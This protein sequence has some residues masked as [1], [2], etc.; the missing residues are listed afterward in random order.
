MVCSQGNLVWQK[1][2]AVGS[3]GSFCSSKM[4]TAKMEGQKW[5]T[6][7]SCKLPG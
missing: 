7:P 5:D 4:W 6:L 1:G 3:R 2:E